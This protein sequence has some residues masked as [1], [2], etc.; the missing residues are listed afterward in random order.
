ML[1]FHTKPDR[2]SQKLTVCLSLGGNARVCLMDPFN[3]IFI[4][5]QKIDFIELLTL[6]A[7]AR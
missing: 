1:R 4:T 2:N 6:C 3:G 5:V 7:L